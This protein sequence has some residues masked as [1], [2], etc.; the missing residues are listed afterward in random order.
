MSTMNPLNGRQQRVMDVMGAEWLTTA[1]IEKAIDPPILGTLEIL[2]SL[3]C[4]RLI[5]RRPVP[6]MGTRFEWAVIY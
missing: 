4:R 1:T 2:K 3:Y 6:E 5:D